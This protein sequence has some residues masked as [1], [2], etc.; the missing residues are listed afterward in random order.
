MKILLLIIMLASTVIAA[1]GSLFLKKGAANLKKNIMSFFNWNIIGGI[2]LY[3]IASI[4]YLLLLKNN[5][6]SVVF[7][8]TSLTYIWVLIISHRYFKENINKVNIIA[9]VL[10]MIGIAMVTL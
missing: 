10:I 1:V 5:D 2:V 3:C 6:L 9:I 4:V 7:P 8:L